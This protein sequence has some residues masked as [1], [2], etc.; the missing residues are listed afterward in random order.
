LASDYRL[1]LLAFDGGLELRAPGKNKGDAVN[2]ILAETGPG[3]PAA[4]LGDDQ[5]DEDAFR[6]IKGKGL[7]ILVRP[8][9]RPTL[10]DVWLRPPDELGRFLRD[11]LLAC[12]AEA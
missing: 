4:Y 3:V 7:A 11:W 8:E 6:A 12:G 1:A 5:T 10:A 9:L 2:A